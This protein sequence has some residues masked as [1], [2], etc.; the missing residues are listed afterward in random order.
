VPSLNRDLR[1]RS[2][3]TVGSPFSILATLD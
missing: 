3:D 2:M 1:M